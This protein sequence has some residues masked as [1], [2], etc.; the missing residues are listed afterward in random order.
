MVER[1][2]S[3]SCG[4]ALTACSTA[5]SHSHLS[6]TDLSSAGEAAPAPVVLP[7]RVD[8][9]PGG[10][11]GYQH[12]PHQRLQRFVHVRRH[13]DRTMTSQY[14]PQNEIEPEFAFPDLFEQFEDGF[15]LEGIIPRGE[16]VQRHPARPH[17][18]LVAAEGLP[19]VG[20]LGRLEGGSAL[21]ELPISSVPT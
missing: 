11:L 1:S 13:T 5:V 19:T 7:Q 8:V 21:L 12:G 14:N 17:V 18:D 16:V 4:G 2:G 20:H 9:R 10:G 6:R 15:P 3:P